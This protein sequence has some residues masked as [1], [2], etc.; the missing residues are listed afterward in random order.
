LKSARY[1][2]T[3]PL[4][5]GAALA[6]APP[7][8]E[9][10]LG[11][12][13]DAAGVA[14][15]LR[16]DVLGMFGDSLHT[17]KPHHDDLREGKRTLLATRALALSSEAGREVLL[18]ALGRSDLD[19]Q[20]AHRCRD[21]IATS[22]ALASVEAAIDTEVERALESLGQL[23]EPARQALTDLALLAAYRDR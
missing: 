16:D 9:R 14:F 23:D 7:D 20:T 13:G 17:G 5:I 11:Q 1:T 10:A 12:Y 8:L 6:S 19:D 22:G 2:V 15:Q 21:L 4:Q 3:R 18:G